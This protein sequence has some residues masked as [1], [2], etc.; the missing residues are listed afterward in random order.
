MLPWAYVFS[1]SQQHELHNMQQWRAGT[2]HEPHWPSHAW[3]PPLPAAASP[4][5]SAGPLTPCTGSGTMG[6]I[7]A[8]RSKKSKS[9][10]MTLK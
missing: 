8:K 4:P 2:L 1:S 5:A 10:R 3:L 6:G 7:G 9:K